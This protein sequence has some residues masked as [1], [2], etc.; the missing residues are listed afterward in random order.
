MHSVKAMVLCVRIS[1]SK[2]LSNP[3]TYVMLAIMAIFHYYSY[4]PLATIA[5]YYGISVTPWVFPFYLS[6]I[7]I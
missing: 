2:L 7:H 3:K 6:L 5:R 1:L 4:A